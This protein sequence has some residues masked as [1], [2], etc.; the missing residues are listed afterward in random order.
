MP[1][2]AIR[3]ERLE[4]VSFS[5]EVMRA[6]LDGDLAR[7]SQKLGATVPGDLRERLGE[8]FLIRLDDID[9]DA[10]VQP[11]VARAIVLTDELGVRR[12]VGS[13]GFHGPPNDDGRVEIGYHV[14]PGF[15]RRGFATEAVRALLEW[16]WREHRISRYRASVAPTNVASLA[17]VAGVGFHQTGRQWDDIDGEELVFELDRPDKVHTERDRR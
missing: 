4:L 6:V 13:V 1:V 7:A 9:R 17:V 3:T 8:L 15:R 14:E 16:A 2:P 5:P 10:S 12:L 11:W